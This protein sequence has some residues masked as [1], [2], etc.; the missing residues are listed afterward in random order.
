MSQHIQHLIDQVISTAES[1]GISRTKLAE[2]CGMTPIELDTMRQYGDILAAA[3]VSLGD[4][5]D[6][7]LVFVARGFRGQSREK[8][9][10]D[11]KTGV[12]FRRGT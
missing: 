1:R 6:L 4:R 12:F 10:N 9:I 3:L 2:E 8:L 7:E 11:I 5:V